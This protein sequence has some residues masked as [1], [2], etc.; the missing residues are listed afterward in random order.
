[1][2]LFGDKLNHRNNFNDKHLRKRVFL[3]TLKLSKKLERSLCVFAGGGGPAGRGV[4]R[5]KEA[6][7]AEEADELQIP[8]W[9]N[10]LSKCLVSFYCVP[11]RN[12]IFQ[13]KLA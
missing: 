13:I 2:Q 1:M 7:S 6:Y 12:H 4:L 11:H 9:K 3:E 8:F 5:G 10:S